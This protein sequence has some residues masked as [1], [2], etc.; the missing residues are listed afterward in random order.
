MDRNLARKIQS[1]E[2][3][4]T[5]LTTLV[6]EYVKQGFDAVGY[7]T[8]EWD[9]AHDLLMAYAPLTK[10]DFEKMEK[11][12]PKNFILPMTTTQ[13]NTA[14]T[15]IAQ[16]LFGQDTPHKVEG[17]G[18]ED[19]VPAEHINTLLRWNAE[20][21]P[22][23]LL[24]YLWVQDA[25][26]YNR[27]VFYNS[28]APILKP[29]P[30]VVEA[31]E[32]DEKGE[33]ILDEAGNPT[34]Y[35]TVRTEDRAVGAFAKM[36]LVSPYDFCFDPSVPVWKFQSGRYAAHRFKVAYVDLVRRSELEIDD[37]AFVLPTAV[38]EIKEKKQKSTASSV[39]QALATNGANRADS[40]ISRT[41]H[42][43]TR[44]NNPLA[45]ESVN[46]DEVG[47]VE[48]VELWVRLIPKDN[49]L[50][51]GQ[52]ATIWQI[53]V[54]NGE[55]VLSVNESPHAHGMFPYTIGESR[56]SGHSQFAPGFALLLKGIQDHVDYLKNRHHEALQRTVGNVFIIDPTMVDVEDFLNPEKEG[57][58]I[59]L[60]AAAQGRKIS[61][62]IQQVPIK[63]L[64]ENFPQEMAEFVKYSET[65][66]GATAQMQG[67]SGES[68]SATEFAG[69]QQM[70]AGRMS[71]VARLLSVGGLV[72]QTRQFVSMFQQ[73]MTEVQAVRY[74]SDTF[75]GPPE[76]VNQ[77]F[78]EVSPDTIQ[79]DFDF[80]AHDGTMPGTDAKRVAAITRV[81]EGAALFPQI[82]APAP[83]NLDPRLLVFAAAKASGI[84]P[85]N[86][87]YSPEG[88]AGAV[89]GGVSLQTGIVP[90]FGGPSTPP[91]GA[92]G[93]EP[94]PSPA[95]PTI[96][97][98]TPPEM[99]SAQPPQVRPQT[100]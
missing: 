42:E 15:F 51:D 12:H 97:S 78:L 63:D 67:A 43:R 100:L 74:R 98:L 11:G 71:A 90:Q 9:V 91:A 73:F 35:W 94:G 93:T 59:Q 5:K 54:A 50:H 70:A 6:G 69:T 18:A 95:A 80:I 4:R 76:L 40:M 32:V 19:E 62:C 13:I 99:P 79:G 86:F 66:S 87:T 17:R 29:S 22:T 7:W 68:E 84:N 64:T 30:E 82:F 23:F 25:L 81:L 28:W 47:M 55:T 33:A 21:Q 75:N 44:L 20:Q 52:S 83:G 37:P 72:G 3:F 57:L 92:A 31:I 34:K 16:V 2:A 41:H 8:G 27:G 58:L 36:E 10:A 85:E 38:D 96:A 61:E 53:V 88:L 24:G 56:P 65:V 49:G 1:N 77:K 89:Q 39:P 26:T 48:C 14:T 45:N 46:K 60:K